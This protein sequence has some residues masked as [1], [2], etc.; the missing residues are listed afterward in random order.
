MLRRMIAI[1]TIGVFAFSFSTAL[2]QVSQADNVTANI[3]DGVGVVQVGDNGYVDLGSVVFEAMVAEKKAMFPVDMPY[4]GPGQVIASNDIIM[5]I[6]GPDTDDCGLYDAV[7][8]GLD[9][10][11]EFDL[12]GE[13]T[14]YISEAGDLILAVDNDE[15]TTSIT[16]WVG[17]R[18]SLKIDTALIEDFQQTGE[19]DDQDIS[20]TSDI[21]VRPQFGEFTAEAM[22]GSLIEPA[23]I[24]NCPGGSCSCTGPLGPASA[25]CPK[26]KTPVC[27]CTKT[28]S[29][30][31]CTIDKVSEVLL[32][33]AEIEES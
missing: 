10:P 29:S 3:T 19:S 23:G 17:L 33:I 5:V 4:V 32:V 6:F 1:M 26:G 7:S 15:I 12:S 28:T 22:W 31:K 2:G 16:A 21:E 24:A 9:T 11:G 13:L 20:H 8:F 25:C 30:G 14:A 27:V 18:S